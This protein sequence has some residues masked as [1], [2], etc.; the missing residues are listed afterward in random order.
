[1]PAKY[2][3]AKKKLKS[4][5]QQQQGQQG[6]RKSSGKAS[7]LSQFNAQ[8]HRNPN[9][10]LDRS[11]T[12][13]I[14]A[15]SELERAISKILLL[16][17]EQD[18]GRLYSTRLHNVALL[19]LPKLLLDCVDHASPG[20]A[21]VN[22][23]CEEIKDFFRSAIAMDMRQAGERVATKSVLWSYTA[24]RHF[25]LSNNVHVCQKRGLHSLRLLPH[26]PALNAHRLELEAMPHASFAKPAHLPPMD[27]S[28]ELIEADLTRRKSKNGP[29]WDD[30]QTKVR[31]GYERLVD[32]L[33]RVAKEFD[34]RGYGIVL[35]EKLT[36][37]WC[38]CGCSTDHLGEVCERTVREEEGSGVRSG[39]EREWDGRGSGVFGWQ[40]DEE[41]D[42]WDMELD[43]GGLE[44]EECDEGLDPE[45]TIGE[46]MEWRYFKAERAKELGNKCFRNSDYESAIKHYTN[47]YDIEP[48][49]P[50]YQ[51]NLAAA[52][53]KLSNWMAAEKACNLALT[54][55]K[56]GKGYWRRAKAR[57]MLGRTIEAVRDIRAVLKLQPGNAEALEELASLL[58]SE[59]QR[60]NA[61]NSNTPEPSD[62]RNIPQS[63]SS[64]ALANKSMDRDD[65]GGGS[66][67]G[68]GSGSNRLHSKPSAKLKSKA[69]VPPFALTELDTRKL[70]INA[71]PLQVEMPVIGTRR[72][73]GKVP[74]FDVKIETYSYPTWERCTVKLSTR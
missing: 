56:S 64:F 50:H 61:S 60:V 70:K 10:H 26:F 2:A 72:G 34:V 28:L 58:P 57:R 38:D 20:W 12:Q 11:I 55:H 22:A 74:S 43:F 29:A 67:S 14:T 59:S 19:Y 6:Q 8:A 54:Q 48:E 36:T 73:K 47:A 42:I 65:V 44:P 15:V 16:R 25:A 46:L 24:L 1:M 66:G 39:K 7:S 45:M 71:L 37:K 3:H 53:L 23:D 51:L 9:P 41:E 35:R 63:S 69:Y 32:S 62:W 52:H 49:L 68:S 17:Y 18:I 13:A 27:E 40:T 4:H 30:W 33:W 5:Q 21:A 31:I